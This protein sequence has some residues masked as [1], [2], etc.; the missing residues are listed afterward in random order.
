[1]LAP[2]F[3][4][5]WGGAGTYILGLLAHLPERFEF[6][7]LTTRRRSFGPALRPGGNHCD[8]SPILPGNLRRGIKIS[9]ISQARDTVFYN[10]QF[11][12][13]CSREVPRLLKSEEIDLIHS[14]SAHMPDLL[15]R[16][17]NVK[18]PIVTTVHNIFQTM[19]EA[20]KASGLEFGLLERSEKFTLAMY[21]VLRAVENA[22]FSRGTEYIAP[23]YWMKSRLERGLCKRSAIAVI[24]NSVDPGDYSEVGRSLPNHTNQLLDHRRIVLYCGRLLAA[25]GVDI[26]IRAIPG[27]IK[28]TRDPRLLFVF[29][30]PASP[31]PYVK[32]LE[33]L[34]ISRESYLFAGPLIREEVI[35]LMKM[36]EVLVVPSFLE[37]CPF[38]V[39]EGMASGTAVVASNVGGIPEIITDGFDGML[40]KPGCPGEL[41]NLVAR[42]LGDASLR[43]HLGQNA[44][45][46]IAERFSWSAN[47]SQYISLYEGQLRR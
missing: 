46:T 37:N 28:A 9:Y 34:N 17:R 25:K 47:V 1:M 33:S 12:C 26:L 18:I 40:V 20:T 24:P 19:R 16:F 23:S 43:L 10:G 15:L 8:D 45:E 44:K 2:E 35:S 6:T 11:Q 21:P 29:A 39:L 22:Y 7:V 4:P 5:T 41:S 42:L 31:V 36:A 27:I 38:T 13:A 14:H 30:G 3:F 32:K